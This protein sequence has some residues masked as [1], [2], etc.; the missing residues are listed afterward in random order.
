MV[1]DFGLIIETLGW[2][3]PH[4]STAVSQFSLYATRHVVLPP[5][6]PPPA[7]AADPVTEDNIILRRRLMDEQPK[8]DIPTF[9]LSESARARLVWIAVEEHV[10]YSDAVDILTDYY[11]AAKGIGRNLDDFHS[12]LTLSRELAVREIPVREVRFALALRQY[13]AEHQLGVQDLDLAV[14]LLKLLQQ[15][16]LTA[17]SGRVA[18]LLEVACKLE[19]SGVS[20]AELEDW[21]ARRKK[22]SRP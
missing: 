14:H 9:S 20:L 1:H 13:L 15:F 12:I 22:P 21:L 5:H 16:G 10:S 17:E 6:S 7:T 8:S 11:C 19:E 4:W 2:T 3:T 18:S